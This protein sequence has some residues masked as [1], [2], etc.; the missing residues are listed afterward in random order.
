MTGVPV[1]VDGNVAANWDIQST[2]IAKNRAIFQ[3]TEGPR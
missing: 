2:A 1:S 3:L